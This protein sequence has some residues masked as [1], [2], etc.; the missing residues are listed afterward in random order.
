M[1]ERNGRDQDVP[2]CS[3]TPVLALGP[4]WQEEQEGAGMRHSIG[5]I[6]QT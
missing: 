2:L 6:S 1:N 4:S 3:E 5:F